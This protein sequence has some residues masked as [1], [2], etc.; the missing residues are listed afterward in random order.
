MSDRLCIQ[1]LRQRLISE[2]QKG[3]PVL[4]GE[5]ACVLRG[6]WLSGFPVEKANKGCKVGGDLELV[7]DKNS[8]ILMQDK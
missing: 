4:S 1:E 5:P 8:L 2:R 3:I 6:R 7:H